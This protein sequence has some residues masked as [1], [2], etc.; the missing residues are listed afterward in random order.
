LRYAV[1][2]DIHSNLHAFLKVLEK[3][4]T[5]SIDQIVCLGDVVGYNA[6][7]ND[8]CDI[9]KERNIPTIC[10]NH[11]A[12]ACGL[13]EPW[14]F[15]PVAMAAAMWTRE[16]LRDDNHAWI[17]SLP[18]TRTMEHF[19][20]V[21]GSPYDRDYYMFTWEE[22]LPHMNYLEEVKSPLCFFGH[23]HSPG[24]FAADGVYTVDDDSKFTLENGKGYF[25]NIGSVGQPRDSDPRASFGVYDSDTATYELVRL[26]YEVDKAAEAVREMGLPDFLA[27]RLFLGR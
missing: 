23:T 25:I 10:G 19:V 9:I 12:V 5:L 22:V 18:D 21:H 17:K 1:I 7:P 6:F 4:E 27:E 26:E 3:I 14:G 15:N 8:C 11:D 13:E 24:I 2:S 16:N 20:M